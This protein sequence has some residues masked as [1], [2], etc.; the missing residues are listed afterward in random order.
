MARAK[1]LV[2]W[3]AL[4]LAV[5]GPSAGESARA[6]S[7]HLDSSFGKLGVAGLP[8]RESA[9]FPLSLG[10]GDAGSLLAPGP[11]GSVFVGG[12]ARSRKGSFLIAHLSARG[13]LVKGFGRRGVST[14][15]AIYSV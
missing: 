10:P 7:W 13:R 9:S 11:Q 14:I 6:A 1:T 4:A 8:V 2:G 15:P 12:Y 3:L 5:A